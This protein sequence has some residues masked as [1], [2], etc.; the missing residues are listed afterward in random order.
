MNADGIKLTCR[1]GLEAATD[2]VDGLDLLP[3]WPLRDPLGLVLPCSSSFPPLDAA[4]DAHSG[5]SVWSKSNPK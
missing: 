4:E 5:D 1:G 2:R 3:R